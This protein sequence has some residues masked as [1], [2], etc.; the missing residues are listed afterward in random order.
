MSRCLCC[1]GPLV[2]GERDYHAECALSIFGSAAPDSLLYSNEQLNLL[3]RRKKRVTPLSIFESPAMLSELQLDDE[4]DPLLR[5]L[6]F[7]E[8]G[9][10]LSHLTMRLAGAAHI[11]TAP[12]AMVRTSDG[13]LRLVV[14]RVDINSMCVELPMENMCQLSQLASEE[15]YDASIEEVM[16]FVE[17]HSSVNRIDVINLWEHIVF[18]WICG[19]SDFNL[20]DIALYE[21]YVG[22]CSLAP[23]GVVRMGDFNK[24][25]DGAMALSV[26]GKRKGIT[27]QDLEGAMRRTGLKGRAMNIIFKKFFSARERWFELVD[28]SLLS[29]EQKVACKRELGTQL[30]KLAPKE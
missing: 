23:L 28:A 10:C 4:H 3:S 2:E 1:Y 12:N 17:E 26:N 9:D 13:E 21:P 27:R 24:P 20:E 6:S 11:V 5:R 16:E 15:R 8:N 29:D 30:D 25:F 14:S 19:N 18:A 7:P 22:I